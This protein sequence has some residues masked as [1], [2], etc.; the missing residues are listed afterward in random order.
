MLQ[1]RSKPHKADLKLDYGKIQQAALDQKKS[2]SS[3]KW[4]LEKLRSTYLSVSDMFRSCP[5]LKEM[6]RVKG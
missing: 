5:N 2:E 3:E 6:M 1:S 4:V